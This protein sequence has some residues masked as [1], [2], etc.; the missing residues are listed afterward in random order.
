MDHLTKRIDKNE[1][2]IRTLAKA[3]LSMRSM[4][5][6]GTLMNAVIFSLFIILAIKGV[7]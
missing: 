6:W 3:M 5:L 1:E 7:V 4:Y 2:D